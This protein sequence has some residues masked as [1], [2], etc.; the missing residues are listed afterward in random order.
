MVVLEALHLGLHVITTRFSSADS[1]VPDGAGLVVQRDVHALAQGM[2]TFVAGTLEPSS[3]D[4]AAYNAE[5]MAEFYAALCIEPAPASSAAPT[6][7][8]EDAT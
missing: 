7:D 2:D 8:A 5:A 6:R 4:S 3:F 1:L